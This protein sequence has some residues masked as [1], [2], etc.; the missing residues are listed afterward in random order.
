MITL[1]QKLLF[2]VVQAF[3]D[4]DQRGAMRNE[5]CCKALAYLGDTLTEAQF[6]SL[7]AILTDQ[8]DQ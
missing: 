6:D 7:K 8:P 4:S 5:E 2:G 1:E 3:I